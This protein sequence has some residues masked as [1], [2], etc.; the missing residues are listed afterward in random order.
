MRNGIDATARAMV[1]VPCSAWRCGH[2]LAGA[3]TLT[4]L[5]P[6]RFGVDFAL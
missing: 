3:N 5:P 4:V 1:G 2:G 6:S